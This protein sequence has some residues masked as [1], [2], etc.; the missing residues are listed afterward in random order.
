MARDVYEKRLFVEGCKG[1]GFDVLIGAGDGLAVK[2][3]IWEVPYEEAVI[4]YRYSTSGVLWRETR[5]RYPQMWSPMRKGPALVQHRC[6]NRWW[7]RRAH[8]HHSGG[9]PTPRVDDN[10]A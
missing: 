7:R 1:C 6:G 9:S 2:L 8:F 4:L 3:D 5:G 10:V